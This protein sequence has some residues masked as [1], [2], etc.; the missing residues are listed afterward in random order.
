MTSFGADWRLIWAT[1]RAFLL[2]WASNPIMLIRSPLIPILL[3]VSFHFVYRATGQDRV[4]GQDVMGFL[5]IGMLATLA[6]TAAVWGSGNALQSEIYA[7]TIGAVIVA[8]GRTP[9]VILGYGL[10]SIIWD[11]PGL[12]ACLAVGIPLGAHFDIADPAAAA[13]CLVAIYLSTL[14]IGVAFGGLFILSRQSNAMSNFLQGPIYLLAGFYVPRSSLPGW[15]EKVS[16]VLPIAYAVDA[17]R[18]TAL[19]GESLSDVWRPLLAM[20]ATSML[21]L[22]AAVW[23]M[24]RLDHAVRRS[25]T[26]DLL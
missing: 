10:G 11:L 17:M 2:R 20:A 12:A 3:L 5:V 19:S 26:L 1:A 8:P 7:G 25:G 15:L 16:D 21:F 6:W 18:R 14:A 4:G 22:F 23:S 24:S 13:I 9:A